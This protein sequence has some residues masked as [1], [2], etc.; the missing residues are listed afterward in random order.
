MPL[1]TALPD[2]FVGLPP[3][4]PSRLIRQNQDRLGPPTP[5]MHFDNSSIPE[6]DSSDM[7]PPPPGGY[8]DDDLGF[9]VGAGYDMTCDGAG[10]GSH[11][12]GDIIEE[13]M[14]APAGPAR[15]LRQDTRPEKTEGPPIPSFDHADDDDVIEEPAAA[16]ALLDAAAA[17]M[18]RQYSDHVVSRWY[19]APEVILGTSKSYKET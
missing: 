2:N 18:N 16:P 1:N 11:Y 7:Y 3:A 9:D 17:A 13:A 14:E 6:L 15:L 10:D 12:D 5:A 8:D 19:R 4:P